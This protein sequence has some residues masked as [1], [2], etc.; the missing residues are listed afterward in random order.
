MGVPRFYGQWIRKYK[1]LNSRQL[2]RGSK[3]LTL[4]IDANALFHKAAQQ[5]YSYGDYASEERQREIKNVPKEDLN[6]EFMTQCLNLIIE[7]INSYHP[8]RLFIAVDGTAPLAKI[9]QQRRRRFDAV[10]GKLKYFD[11]NAI[12]PGT[13]LMI[14]LDRF[15]REGLQR[16]GSEHGLHRIVYSGHLEPGEG[17]HKIMDWIRSGEISGDEGVHIIHGLDAD[18]ISLGL[19]SRIKTLYLLRDDFNTRE[20]LSIEELRSLIHTLMPNKATAIPD[21]V[22]ILLLIGNDFVPRPI[23]ADGELGLFIDE[24]I[25][26]YNKI[27]EPIIN[28]ETTSDFSDKPIEINWHTFS[29]LMSEISKNEPTLIANVFQNSANKGTIWTRSTAEGSFN[30]EVF[31]SHWYIKSLSYDDESNE[32]MLDSLVNLGIDID[33]ILKIT[34][35]QITQMCKEY[36]S[37]MIWS[38]DYYFNGTKNVS[39]L[40]SYPYSYAPLLS[41]LAIVAASSPPSDEHLAELE[42]DEFLHPIH[43]L[44]SVLPPQSMDLVPEQYRWLMTPTPRMP[45]SPILDLYPISAP[46]DL[47]GKNMRWQGVVRI[48]PVSIHLVIAAE[49]KAQQIFECNLSDKM[50]RALDTRLRKYKTDNPEIIARMEEDNIKLYE[51]KINKTYENLKTTTQLDLLFDVQGYRPPRPIQVRKPENI[52][53]LGVRH[54]P[55]AAKIERKGRKKQ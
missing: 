30:Y 12:T 53:T 39:I 34:S 52:F 55:P 54:R 28:F 13:E 37:A 16:E 33:D 48:H 14:D 44:L 36:L 45:P 35:V 9:Q 11:S 1:Q 8:N 18:L 31:R 29:K 4:S 23:V 46:V 10:S 21:F 20:F 32:E 25:K 3:V 47:D 41:D 40:I 6:F 24:I 7:L 43:Q 22:A 49:R 17:E 42:G 5:I 50:R 15:L 51:A 38:M 19:I 26:V 2:P 27:N